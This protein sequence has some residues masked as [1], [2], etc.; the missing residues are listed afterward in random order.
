VDVGTSSN[1][2]T[3]IN[4]FG[5][6]GLVSAV[7][8]TLASFVLEYVTSTVPHT[9]A[10]GTLFGIAWVLITCQENSQKT[11]ALLQRWLNER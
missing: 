1:L 6:F 5:V 7:P 2:V 10:C 9:A 3:S 4:M 11:V 8:F